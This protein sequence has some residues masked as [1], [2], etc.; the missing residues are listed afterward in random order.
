MASK[1]NGAPQQLVGAAFN[2][3]VPPERRTFSYLHAY[4]NWVYSAVTKI[5]KEVSGIELYLYRRKIVRNQV[6]VE[7]VQDH[8]ALSLLYS[9]ND[10]MTKETFFEI[11]QTYEDLTGEAVWAIIRDEAG[12]PAELWPLRPD[13]VSVIPDKDNFIGGYIYRVGGAALSLTGTAANEVKFDKK[14]II[15]FKYPSV[16]NPYRGQGA[17]QAGDLIIDIDTYGDEWNRNFFYN[18]ALPSL[19]FTTDQ[20]LNQNQIK[21]F[22]EMY[23]DK[24]QGRNNAHK[25]AFFGGGMK[26][27]EVGGNVRELD[28]LEGKKY[29]R[30]EILALFH[31]AKSDIGVYEDV[32][33]A[34]A[35]A[36]EARFAAEVVKPRMKNLVSYLNEFYLINWPDEDLFFDF[37]DPTPEDT[38]LK[39]QIYSNG[40]Q[41]G[42]L[43]PNEVRE[44]E[45]LPPVENG[46]FVY[47]PF[48]LTQ[49]GSSDPNNQ[50]KIIDYVKLKVSE[51]K[52]GKKKLSRKLTLR[53]APQK[54]YRLK[55]HKLKEALK[56]DLYKLVYALVKNKDQQNKLNN[57]KDFKETF[58]K[59]MVAKTDVE[60]KSMKEKIDNLFADQ[61][62]E[63]MRNIA[64]NY[65]KS[66]SVAARRKSVNDYL[67]DKSSWVKI[68][69]ATMSPF[70]RKIVLDKA[71]EMFGFLG[72]SRDLDLSTDA[73]ASFLKNN[74]IDLS[75]T[76]NDTTMQ[77]LKDSLS[78]G[79]ANGE[80]VPELQ[81]R[82]N[83]IFNGYMENRSELIARTEVIRAS[84]FATEETYKQSQ[85]VKKKEWLTAVDERTCPYCAKMDG[86]IVAVEETFVKEDGTV[87]TEAGTMTADYG[88]VRYPPLHPRCRC[89]IIPV[90]E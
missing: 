73:V 65:P 62:A 32:N 8:E 50:K 52:G 9:V 3:P 67:F 74:P 10:F 38:Q 6:T 47:I 41:N 40:L 77:E 19:F 81:D 15:F 59:N 69:L 75:T 13:W 66:R 24:F 16:L 83:T 88:A 42:W 49:M 20:K 82:V 17:V 89:T 23:R 55:K 27:T 44:R 4:K 48:N 46:D 35:Q 29:L 12:K 51:V 72:M 18:S 60:E 34:S 79:A 57:H 31:M 78:E 58:W 25:V 30:D 33:R 7:E 43:T 45:N 56:S 61:K 5:A 54:L 26:P 86:K 80:S 63:V 39:L 21:Q 11:T 53:V 64:N 71:R 36:A 76:V 84:N 37:E 14:D 2:F 90:L 70:L 87:E 28:F 85:I 1:T 22:M 68:W